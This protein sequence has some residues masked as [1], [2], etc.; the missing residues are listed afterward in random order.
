[1]FDGDG[2]GV[3]GSGSLVVALVEGL[4]VDSLGRSSS[5]TFIGGAGM[6][7][8]EGGNPN[9]YGGNRI[10]A[11]GAAAWAVATAIATFG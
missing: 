1:M 9:G 4:V 6:N 5:G 7:P 11:T 2:S 8:I 10:V 3:V